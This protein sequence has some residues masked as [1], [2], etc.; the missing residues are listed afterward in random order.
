MMVGM[1]DAGKI[2][3][4]V[5]MPAFNEEANIEKTVRA[6]AAA[7]SNAGVSAEIV[8]VND[9]SRDRTLDV[10]MS[11]EKD[12]SYLNVVNHPKNLGYGAALK[13]AIAASKGESVVTIDSDGQFDIGE[14]P[15][16]FKH[17]R[18]GADVVCGYRKKKN[19]TFFRVFANRGLNS[20]ISVLF[21]VRFNDINCAF[22]LYRGDSLRSINIESSGYQAPS[23]IMIK[24]SRLGCAVKEVGV[25]HL[26]REGGQSALRPLR[27]IAQM[28]AFLVYLKLKTVLYNKGILNSL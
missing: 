21:K 6:C 1:E 11:L 24:L 28:T 15:V 25:S 2:D 7:L 16:F 12:V 13:T 4:S 17:W 8:V 27:T 14:L 18:D 9:G 3:I 22:R 10:L 23:E 19:D 5:V 20:L 26:P